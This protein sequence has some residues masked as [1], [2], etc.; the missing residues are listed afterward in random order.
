MEMET[1]GTPQSKNQLFIRKV[2][3]PTVIFW[4]FSTPGECHPPVVRGICRSAVQPPR[5]VKLSTTP[6]VGHRRYQAAVKVAK[7]SIPTP[8]PPR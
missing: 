8:N 3:P 5:I 7:K 2:P 1:F 4:R 6:S